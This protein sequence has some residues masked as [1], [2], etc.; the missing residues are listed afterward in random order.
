MVLTAYSYVKFLHFANCKERNV[1]IVSFY[2]QNISNDVVSAQRKVF[3]KFGL[4]IRQVLFDSVHPTAID[5][6]IDRLRYFDYVIVFDIDAI[7]LTGDAIAKILYNCDHYAGVVG[8]AQQSNHINNDHPYAG[9][10]CIA[11]SQSVYEKLGRPKFQ[12]TPRSDVGEEITWIAQEKG[13][14]V[15]LLNVSNIDENK[16]KLGQD[17][18]F[19]LGTTYENIV[20]H[21]FECRLSTARFLAKCKSV[22]SESRYMVPQIYCIN[23]KTSVARKE[24]M[25]R[26][27][28]NRGISA[29]FL[30][31]TGS[32]DV[33]IQKYVSCPPDS[34]NAKVAAC[35]VSH[36]NAIK[37]FLDSGKD[38]C[39]VCE[40]DVL[41]HNDFNSRLTNIV[42]DIPNETSLVCL[43]Y[44][45]SKESTYSLCDDIQS[46]ER[47]R[48]L[49]TDNIWGTQMYWISRNYA[50]KCI[51]MFDK[52]NFG[53]NEKELL[54]TAEVITRKSH[55]LIVFPPLALEDCISS[56]INGQFRANEHIKFVRD[57]NYGDFANGEPNESP[58]SSKIILVT[59]VRNES[60]VIQRMIK[61]ALPVID[62]VFVCDTGSDD[63]TLELAREAATGLPYAEQG[64]RWRDF[65]HNRTKTVEYAKEFV[66]T[67]GWNPENT[68]LLL[69]DGDQTLSFSDASTARAQLIGFDSVSIQQIGRDENYMNTRIVR[70]SVP[71]KYVRRTHEY[72]D[73][74]GKTH[75]DAVDVSVYEH[76]DGGC[77]SDKYQRD[78]KLLHLDLKDNPTDARSMFYL[79]RTLR[80]IGDAHNALKWYRRRVLINEFEEERWMAQLQLG[81]L[82]LAEKNI[83]KGRQELWKAFS[84]RP[85]RS[86]PFFDLANSYMDT[87]RF[88]ACRIA[89]LGKLIPYPDGDVLFIER[90]LYRFEFDRILAICSFY[91]KEYDQGLKSADS[92]RLMKHC[93]R[94]QEAMDHLIWYIKPLKTEWGKD[95]PH[96]PIDAGWN[97]CNPSIIKTDNGYAIALRTVDYSIDA[98]GAYICKDGM[99]KTRSYLIHFDDDLNVLSQV[100]L[101]SLNMNTSSIIKNIEDIRLCICDTDCVMGLGVRCDKTDKEHPRMY[102]FVWNTKNGKCAVQRELEISNPEFCEKNWLPY[103]SQ[104][105]RLR[106]LYSSDPV[107]VLELTDGEL[108][109]QC[110]NPSPYDLSGFRG[111]ASPIAWRENWLYVIHETTAHRDDKKRTY[112]HRFCLMNAKYEFLKCSEPFYFEEKGIEFCAGMARY[113]DGVILTYGI[114]DA[115]ARMAYVTEQTINSMLGVEKGGLK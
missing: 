11:F 95:V 92:L 54:K 75:H 109:V 88:M 21:A 103:C 108:K 115:R 80:D 82:E 59:M 24:R 62:A 9:P 90:N 36:L 29:I 51:A 5:N 110:K 37:A 78:V 49:G 58:L 12:W 101:E 23:Q 107:T 43:G 3:E 46:K 27:F 68:Y 6:E 69:L 93:W 33:V 42:Q 48:Y 1:A 31:A 39:I 40:D 81:R 77:R 32:S 30:D 67:L 111:S 86:E 97:P 85:W 114:N 60:K 113:K 52:Q 65:S 26:R 105:G 13:I 16:W 10:S 61:S 96:L 63:N 100:E 98:K 56:E 72:L 47:L 25:I 50:E 73:H 53:L 76:G 87:D 34:I 64:E 2:M 106:I 20:Y 4:E 71:C 79:A 102:Q 17:G 7:P 8:I 70:A 74:K 83:S 19:G 15:C 89:R 45:A 38:A 91:I 112:V 104:K 55:G 28:N 14:P 99:V 94:H 18:Q 35:F 41:L 57:Y 66:K 44:F 22:L 84:Q